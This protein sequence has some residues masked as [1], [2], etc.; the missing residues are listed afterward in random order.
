MDQ[1]SARGLGQPWRGGIGWHG[2]TMAMATYTGRRPQ[3]DMSQLV[4]RIAKPHHDQREAIIFMMCVD[5]LG[6]AADFA[7]FPKEATSPNRSG[8]L[9]VRPL[10][11]L[12]R[13]T[14]IE[15]ASH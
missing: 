11:L 15:R 3:R 14:H 8:N 2:R 9:I 5:A 1:R 12:L 4:V 13:R 7:W 6:R 10:H